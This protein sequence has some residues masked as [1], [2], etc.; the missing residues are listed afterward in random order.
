MS[1]QLF[2]NFPFKKSYLS[3]DF[4]VSENNL[5]IEV[6]AAALVFLVENQLRDREDIS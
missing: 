3:Q 1:E 5:R 2:F 4:Y 6:A